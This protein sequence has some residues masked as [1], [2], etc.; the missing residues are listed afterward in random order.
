MDSQAWDR[1]VQ[2]Y[3]P[4]IYAWARKR[5]ASAE[6][7]ADVMQDVFQVLTTKLSK[8]DKHSQSGSFR[9][10]LYTVTRNRV[11][12]LLRKREKR[13][14]AVGGTGAQQMLQDYPEQLDHQSEDSQTDLV[15]LR[16][17]A[18]E[19][20][21]IDFESKTWQA[22]YRTAIQGDVPADV[23]ADLGISVWAVYKARSRILKRLKE[24]FHEML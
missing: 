18:L 5:G 9:A 23:A 2:V 13:E 15:H 20:M 14:L 17:R 7:A 24:D 1:L 3:G 4:M 21:S 11:V 16:R 19:S 6:D 22:F 12:D 8:F 10:W